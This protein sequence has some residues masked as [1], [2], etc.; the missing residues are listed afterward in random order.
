MMLEDWGP[1]IITQ[2]LLDLEYGEYLVD[3]ILGGDYTG[4][5]DGNDA[6]IVNGGDRDDASTHDSGDIKDDASC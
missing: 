3:Y 6:D 5:S 1:L 4:D 2:L